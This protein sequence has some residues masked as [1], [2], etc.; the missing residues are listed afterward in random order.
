[1]SGLGGTWRPPRASLRPGTLP[2]WLAPIEHA[3]ARP[4][5]ASL[6][7]AAEHRRVFILV[8]FVII[9]GLCLYACLPDEPQ[10]LAFMAAALAFVLLIAAAILVTRL[11]HLA[12][13]GAALLAGLMLLP[14]HGALFGTRM[15]S[16]PMAG[17]FSGLVDEI[18]SEGAGQRRIVVSNLVRDD[19]R[20]APVT[21]ARLVMDEGVPISAGDGFV[22]RIRLAPVPGPVLPGAF[23]GQFHA[24]FRGIGAYGSV[25]GDFETVPA[26]AGWSLAG[27]VETVRRDIARRI[28]MVLDDQTAAV[29]IAMTIGDQSRISDETR[30]V[31]AIS[32]LAHIYSISG[33]HLS[34]VAG[35]VYVFLRLLL[36]LL[37]AGTGRYVPSK[38]IAAAAGIIAAA[39]YLLLAGGIA[40]VPAFRSTLMLGLVFGGVLIGRKALSMRNVA[41]AG[42]LIVLIDPAN[43]FRASF[44]LSFSAVVALIGVYELSRRQPRLVA[45]GRFERMVNF[46][47][48]AA[49]TS[50]I[51][52]L[53]TVLFSAYHFQQ[54]APLSVLANVMVLPVL[55]FVIMPFGAIG[56]AA[57]ALGI[58][59]PLLLLTGWGIDR[60]I[61]VAA[62]VT[63]WSDGIEGNPILTPWSL[64]I[65]LVGLAWFAVLRGRERL[66]GP[67]L[68]LPLV[69]AFGLD[70]RPDVLIADSTQAVALRTDSGMALIAGRAGSFAV[71]AWSDH[72]DTDIA[73]AHPDLQCDSLACV[74][75]VAD[76]RIALIRV[77][78]AFAEECGTGALIVTRL[79][80]PGFC[81]VPGATVI[82]AADLRR[83]GVHWLRRDGEGWEVRPVM[84]TLDRPWRVRLWR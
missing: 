2:G 56:V 14:V 45:E 75:A 62:I 82:D 50:L 43:V 41:L 8:P 51:A 64:V 24:Y 57:M 29:A 81:R 84:P 58:E 27:T 80:A 23:D 67:V 17:S 4:L 47:A 5:A 12:L 10:M 79:Y 68:V 34:I 13:L 18:L 60:M 55:S 49:F 66:A 42:L 40:N 25:I 6:A 32:G 39:R 65:G 52:G 70:T 83:G 61:D 7:D 35:G 77:A 36:V 48:A 38:A 37:A 69:L 59:A 46:V 26:E 21:R 22:A 73:A 78:D 20:T 28:E 72:Y 33:L 15:L 3:V 53:A 16:F 1:M 74:A 63:H 31:M 44:Q 71:N 11:R 9:A 54:T 30:A 19:G 76:T